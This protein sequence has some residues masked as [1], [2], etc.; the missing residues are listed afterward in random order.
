VEKPKVEA[1]VEEP[2]ADVD[3]GDLFGGD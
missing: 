3:M 1:K 2:E